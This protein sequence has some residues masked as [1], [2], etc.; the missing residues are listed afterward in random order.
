MF[1]MRTFLWQGGTASVLF[2]LS[3]DEVIDQVADLLAS[4]RVHV[5]TTPLP[6]ARAG[7][8]ASGASATQTPIPFP[9]TPQPKASS[10]ERT[11]GPTDPSTFPLNLDGPAQTAALM[12]A[13]AQGVPFC[14]E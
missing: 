8:G 13:A 11:P 6:A 9:L 14:P 2:R 1:A 5:H 3:D 4:G 12:S 10:Q 7:S